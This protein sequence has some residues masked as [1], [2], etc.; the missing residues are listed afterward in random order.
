MTVMSKCFIAAA[1]IQSFVVNVIPHLLLVCISCLAVVLV[2][3]SRLCDPGSV[4]NIRGVHQTSN[5]LW[6]DKSGSIQLSE[7][8]RQSLGTTAHFMVIDVCKSVNKLALLVQ[9]SLQDLYNDADHVEQ[10]DRYRAIELGLHLDN[11]SMISY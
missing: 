3:P 5:V 11:S 1:Y 2:Y 9:M 4:C 10:I 6:P 8:V 7:T